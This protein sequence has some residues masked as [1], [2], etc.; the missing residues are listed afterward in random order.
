VRI[1]QEFRD[2]LTFQLLQF[3]F[4]PS[5]DGK[6]LS[7]NGVVAQ[8]L[9]AN[10]RPT[11]RE[12][13]ESRFY[14]LTM[15]NMFARSQIVQPS[16]DANSE[17][18]VR[19]VL[20]NESNKNEDLFA[21]RE[22][23]CNEIKTYCA[24]RRLQ[25]NWNVAKLQP[26]VV[27]FTL[28]GWEHVVFSIYY[29]PGHNKFYVRMPGDYCLFE[30]DRGDQLRDEESDFYAWVENGNDVAAW[31]AKSFDPKEPAQGNNQI[32]TLGEPG[33]WL[34]W[35]FTYGFD[36]LE[37][38]EVMTHRKSDSQLVNALLPV[39]DFEVTLSTLTFIDRVPYF[40]PR[41][42]EEPAPSRDTTKRKSRIKL[43]ISNE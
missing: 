29:E 42:K 37:T 15:R 9:P 31:A 7:Q 40:H 13:E 35:M 20:L 30:I 32:S 11:D 3:G 36:K 22:R 4:Q 38:L 18:D 27:K 17:I 24:E 26:R 19:N 28:R 8:F 1:N 16:L 39:D 12:P 2:V 23:L 5:T 43:D 6:R 34:H 33:Q 41:E 14:T 21:R 10:R 25:V